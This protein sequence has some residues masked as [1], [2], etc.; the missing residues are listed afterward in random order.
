MA[1]EGNQTAATYVELLSNYILPEL[2]AAG[3][4]MVFMQDNAPCHK[5]KK[6]MSFLDENNVETLD[7]PPQSPDMN[8][9]E[10]LWSIIKRRRQKKFGM[11]AT[12]IA[13]IDQIFDIWDNIEPEVIDNLA[14]SANRRIEAVLKAKGN[15]AK[16]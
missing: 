4:P 13:L 15:V 8:P 11:P 5:A 3:R 6:V 2:R 1:L 12:R 16:Y 9:I 10:N 7:W 14:Q